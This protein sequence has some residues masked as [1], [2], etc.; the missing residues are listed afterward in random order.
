L[1]K[2]TEPLEARTLFSF[3]GDL[4]PS[5]GGG[6]G[7]TT[8]YA[9]QPEVPVEIPFVTDVGADRILTVSYS[10]QVGTK[11]VE[12]DLA[13]K[14]RTAFGGGDGYAFADTH[15]IAAA[16]LLPDNKVI[17]VG[18]DIISRFNSDGTV[19][20]TFGGGD[21]QA[22]LPVDG[23]SSLGI[24]PGGKLVVGWAS[25]SDPTDVACGV[26]RL[27]A[28]GS[29]DKT[30][31]DGDG[32][33]SY[34]VAPSSFQATDVAAAAKGRVFFTGVGPGDAAP[35]T[36]GKDSSDTLV[37]C[38]D[39]AG[40]FD[41][42]FGGGDGVAQLELGKWEAPGA[43]TLDAQGRP[44]VAALDESD[45]K[46]VVQRLTASG[47][48]DATFSRTTVATSVFAHADN[49]V[50]AP[51][52]KI[53]VGARDGFLG[54]VNANGGV[55]ATFG[56]TGEGFLYAVEGDMSFD[57]GADGKIVDTAGE[58]RIERRLAKPDANMPIEGSVSL[59]SDGT[60]TYTGGSRGADTAAL[61]GGYGSD[62]FY[63]DV[64]HT[65]FRYPLA[66]VKR[67]E[68]YGNAGDDLL[69][70]DDFD[71]PVPALLDG[72]DGD[73]CLIS[74]NGNDKLIGRAGGDQLYGNGGDDTLDGGAG[75]DRMEGGD[76]ADTVDYSR[77]GNAVHVDLEGDD[78]DGASFEHDTVWTDVE[79]ILGGSGN[80]TLVGNGKANYI[81]GGPG[82]DTI[83]GG[84]GNDA[85]YGDAGN[86]RIYGDAG[87]DYIDSRDGT[88][89]PV[90]D[91]GTGSFDK[92]K[93]DS[94]EPTTG[95]E[96]ILA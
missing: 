30:F 18:N 95:I 74:G 1:T 26:A 55:D 16:A 38:L 76:G 81:R 54:R 60:L 35:W 92:V 7:V 85:L 41:T 77:R 72:G 66:S 73:D 82:N 21:G 90:L 43:L 53:V 34:P 32:V 17:V 20:K 61:S 94:F 71:H 12:F 5:F 89:D 37:I 67:V 36:I 62:F 49:V 47:A 46:L 59:K 3:A 14:F 8:F 28:D 75:A 19:D 42:T 79:H 25:T 40:K 84:G 56:R 58:A 9:P 93:K 50:V 23:V 65:R 6:D 57:I 91:G 2:R 4:D 69:I 63:I 83:S 78:D 11:L 29:V 80:D 87:D 64:G 33:V 45:N 52:G 31:G 51:D 10:A 48:T 86:D 24:A 13:G 22:P 39:S 68:M 70:V 88:V 96:Q 27:N 15:G 44:V